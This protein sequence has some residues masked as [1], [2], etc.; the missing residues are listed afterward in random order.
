LLED[1]EVDAEED[2]EDEEDDGVVE[3]PRVE[4]NEGIVVERLV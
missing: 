1:L 2:E 4:I 3:H